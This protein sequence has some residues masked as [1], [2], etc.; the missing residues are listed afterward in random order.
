MFRAYSATSLDAALRYVALGFHVFPCHTIES[1]ICS[2]GNPTCSDAGKHPLTDNGFY[3]ATNDPDA[4]RSFFA[5]PY[6][7]ANVAI[8]TGGVSGVWV[9]D[10]ALPVRPGRAGTYGSAWHQPAGACRKVGS[11]ATDHQPTTSAQA[12]PDPR[13]G[14]ANR[15]SAGLR[16]LPGVERRVIQ[17][18]IDVAGYFPSNTARR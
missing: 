5:G 3:A 1:G 7:I 9:T 10:V 6:A 15:Q 11:K 16:A 13:Y 4:V 2:C 17:K 8:R 14:A 12:F 18:C